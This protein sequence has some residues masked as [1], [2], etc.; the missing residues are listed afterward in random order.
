[1]HILCPHCHNPIELVK[2]APRAEVA[3]PACGS[4]FRLETD[5]TTGSETSVGWK[6]GR[7]DLIEKV[8]EGGFGTVYKARDAELDRT[9]A[10][11]VPRAGFLAGLQELDRFLREARAAAQ[12]RHPSIVAVHEVGES[13]GVPFIVSDFVRGV[14]LADR[15]SAWRPTFRDAAQLVAAVAEALHY[16]HERGVVHRDVKPQNIMMHE[17][18]TPCVMDFGLARRDTGEITMTIEGQVLGTPAYM[19]PE[20]ARGEGHTADSRSDVYSAG[21]VLYQLLTI[22]L[23]FRG[24]KAM[25]LY[26]VEHDEPRPPRGLNDHIPRDL[27]TITLKAMAKEPDRR[28]ATAGDFAADLRRWLDGEP[29][30]ARPVGRAERAVKWAR[31]NPGVARLL[32]VLVA[33]AVVSLVLALIAWS[34]VRM[35]GNAYFENLGEYSRGLV[36][37]LVAEPHH[38][39]SPDDVRLAAIQQAIGYW[40]LEQYE[41]HFVKPDDRVQDRNEDE[42]RVLHEF[43]ND[44]RLL[45]RNEP[46]SSRRVNHY[47]AA[48]H[49][50]ETCIRC[51]KDASGEPLQPGDLIAVLVVNT[52][53]NRGENEVRPLEAQ[54]IKVLIVSLS[55]IVGSFLIVRYIS[56]KPVKHRKEQEKG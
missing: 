43:Q 29:I 4:T 3:C 14:S 33:V 27:E 25:V 54:L 22:E 41:Y 12:L 36:P 52:A 24:T 49:A 6:V 15:L 18:N 16:A 40:G 39:A 46:E 26:Q 8:G 51:H 35:L 50:T 17:D 42:L 7:F 38:T 21:V 34:T 31:R 55:V 9:V 13:D 2:I 45:E 5:V 30:Q 1:M 37:A 32:V 10:V 44:P 19:S 28:Y 53:I 20:Q 11:K 23:P 56:S 47:Y 48:I